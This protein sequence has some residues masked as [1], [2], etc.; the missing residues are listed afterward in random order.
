MMT[1]VMMMMMMMMIV[2]FKVYQG[3]PITTTTT[4]D[5][6]NSPVESKSGWKGGKPKERKLISQ[7]R[8]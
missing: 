4:Y 8:Q 2:R 1:M 6:S 7:S 5:S 3:M